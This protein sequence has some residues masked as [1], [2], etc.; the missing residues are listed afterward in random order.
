MALL[1]VAGGWGKS[2]G[3]RQVLLD[4]RSMISTELSL[5]K[6]ET[7]R[8]GC[9][10]AWNTFTVPCCTL[11]AHEHVLF[12]LCERN[13]YFIVLHYKNF[14]FRPSLDYLEWG[15]G[16]LGRLLCQPHQ[17]LGRAG[18]HRLKPPGTSL[19]SFLLWCMF[20]QDS[21]PSHW[22]IETRWST[23]QFLNGLYIER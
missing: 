5:P 8:K 19:F 10:L 14:L 15:G 2:A 18:S 12:I 6:N 11:S 21:C 1:G 20:C 7:L 17:S 22:P 9:F 3:L 23:S 13:I 4:A 16:I